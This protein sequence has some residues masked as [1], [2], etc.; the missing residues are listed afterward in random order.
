[1]KDEKEKDWE[2]LQKRTD[3]G[4]LDIERIY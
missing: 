1:M 2:I 4:Y 3:N